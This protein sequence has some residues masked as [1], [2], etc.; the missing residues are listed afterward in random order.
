MSATP[1]TRRV[2][3]PAD[4]MDRRY[5]GGT[6]RRRPCQHDAVATDAIVGQ[7]IVLH[8]LNGRQGARSD[9]AAL[10]FPPPP[11]RKRAGSTVLRTLRPPFGGRAGPLI[12]PNDSNHNPSHAIEPRHHRIGVPYLLH[13]HRDPQAK[14]WPEGT[15]R[16][17]APET[18]NC[19]S[20][21]VRPSLAGCSVFTMLPNTV[22]DDR[23][24]APGPAYRAAPG[25]PPPPRTAP[26]SGRARPTPHRAGSTAMSR[27][28]KSF[29]VE[30][31]ELA[32][33]RRGW[34]A[35]T[36]ASRAPCRSSAP[37]AH[38][39]RD[40]VLQVQRLGAVCQITMRS[41]SSTVT[42]SAVRS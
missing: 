30:L 37:R 32:D 34:R 5:R 4:L 25:R 28:V 13:L 22:N 31:L 2:A 38:R 26:R 24:R 42:V 27:R 16:D 21:G 10:H 18:G 6:R 19:R 17:A 9:D 7:L 29:S 3:R 15:S 39:T 36:G 1:P 33:G 14:I 12:R 8:V 23:S 11:R 40:L 35:A 20:R 41:I